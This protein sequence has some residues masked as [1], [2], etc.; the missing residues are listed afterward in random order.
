VGLL[1]ESDRL[2][3]LEW[4]AVVVVPSPLESL[5]LLALEGMAIGTPVL[6]NARADVLVDHCRRSNA[7]LFY[8]DRDE[9]VECT[10]LLLADR[11]LSERLGKNGKA[12]V[13]NHYHWDVIMSKYDRLMAALPKLTRGATA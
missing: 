11:L 1:S 2:R 10:N 13:R 9:F 3:A 5:S 6:C 7:G 12:Y 4:A 8:S